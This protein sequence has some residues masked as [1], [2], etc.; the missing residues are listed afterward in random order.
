MS[1]FNFF[2]RIVRRAGRFTEAEDTSSSVTHPFDERNV[3][4]QLPSKVRHLF[5]DAHYAEATFE[6][7]KFLD[8]EL[9]RHSGSHESG[10]KL[11]MQ[12]LNEATP[13]IKLNQLASISDKDEQKG[14][15]FMFAGAFM[16]IRNPRGHE[17]EVQDNLD[18]CLDHLSLVS[19]LLRRLSDAGYKLSNVI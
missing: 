12:I 16:G 2:E 8:K 4:A 18:T 11:A 13:L 15:Q 7:F 1:S 3:Y 19:M 6:A 9:Q 5:D 17:Y 14:Y 10:F